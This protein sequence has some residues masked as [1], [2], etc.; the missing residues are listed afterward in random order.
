MPEGEEDEH[1]SQSSLAEEDRTGSARGWNGREWPVVLQHVAD[2]DVVFRGWNE[3]LRLQRMHLNPQEEL[4][5][6]EQQGELG[7]APAMTVGERIH[8]GMAQGKQALQQLNLLRV[9]EPC[10]REGRGC[11]SERRSAFW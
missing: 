6:K 5:E 1:A 11:G 4:K 10:R 2:E 8:L 3:A 7:T 9:C